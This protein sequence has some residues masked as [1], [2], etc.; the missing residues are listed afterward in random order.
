M[1]AAVRIFLK[2]G[3][4]LPDVVCEDFEV[5]HNTIT[6]AVTAYKFKGAELPRP[7]H[8]NPQEI[9]AVYDMPV[10]EERPANHE[11]CEHCRG[12]AYTPKPFKVITQTA[13]VRDCVFNFCP[14]C[15]ADLREEGTTC[16]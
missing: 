1:K 11:R 12:A 2:N 9:V 6:G 10:K 4:Q 5:T 8:I 16:D 14:V 15:G 13:A 7:M 3:V